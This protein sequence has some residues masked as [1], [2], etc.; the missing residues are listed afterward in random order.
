MY[1]YIHTNMHCLSSSISSKKKKKELKKN[2]TKHYL[3]GIPR[4]TN[5]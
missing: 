2:P 1:T 5:F 3:F 4:L